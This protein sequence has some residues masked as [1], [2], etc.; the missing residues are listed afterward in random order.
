MSPEEFRRHG[1]AAIDWIADYWSSLDEL[2]VRSQVAPGDVASQLPPTAPE[3]GEGFDALLDD[4]DRV[5][6]PGLT[7]WQHPRFFAYFPANSSPAAILGDLISSG[8]GAQGM[9]WATSPAVTEVEQVVLDWFARALGL[10]EAFLSTGPGGGVISDTASTATFT[11]VL[12]ALHRAS[13]GDVRRTG[14][15]AVPWRLYASSQAHSS[16]VKAAMMAGL[17]EESVRAIGVDQATQQIDVDALRAAVASDLEAGLRP[18]LVHGC[19]GSTST[20]ATDDLAALAHV[21]EEHGLWLHVDAA[22]AG[23][24]AVCPELREHLVGVERADSFVTNPHKWL[25]TTFDCS[26]FWVRDRAALVGALSILPEYLRNAA[27]ESGAVVDY[28]DWH[29]QLGRRFRALKLWAVLRTYGLEGVRA[30]VRSG[31]ALAEHAEAL[32]RADE[33]FEIVTPRSLSLVVFRHVAGDDA[34]LAV[35]EDVNASGEA[36]LSHTVVEG[37]TAMRLAVGSWTTRSEDVDR[38]WR[39]LQ[40]A[41]D[42]LG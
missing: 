26:T 37:R 19:A 8:I 9:L 32:V 24:A 18:L 1:H 33:R 41:A 39:A 6:V 14:V 38:T 27:T 17:G 35:M 36:Y 10:P 23:V 40:Q 15:G 4:L 16:L 12:A 29:P 5:V 25:L 13:D 31:V 21:A 30:H 20:G 11:A 34:T 2:P 3:W 7:H 42:R 28:R 22:W